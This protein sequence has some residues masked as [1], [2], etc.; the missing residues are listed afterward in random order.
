[1][2]REWNCKDLRGWVDSLS[3]GEL[4]DCSPGEDAA[5]HLATCE[6]CRE[7]YRQARAVESVL[8]AWEAPAPRVNIQAKVMAAIA[9]HERQRASESRAPGLLD[10]LRMICQWRVQMPGYAL[11]ALVLLLMGSLAWNVMHRTTGTLQA[12]GVALPGNERAT[13]SVSITPGT[14]AVAERTV[15]NDQLIRRTV[16]TPRP[17]RI[18]PRGSAASAAVPLV[19]IMGVPPQSPDNLHGQDSSSGDVL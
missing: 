4:R 2:N 17:A 18:E 12:Q 13:V 8:P 5:R 6:T 19:V 11:A 14:A 3:V 10:I 9:S 15:S 1:M 7:Y 16:D